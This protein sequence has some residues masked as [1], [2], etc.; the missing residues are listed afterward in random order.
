MFRFPVSKPGLGIEI[1]ASAIRLVA[2]SRKGA[3]VTALFAKKAELPPETIGETY[4]SPNILNVDRFSMVL[5]VCLNEAPR[6]IRRA[7][8]SLPDGVFRVQTF[9]F[10]ALPGKP[11]DRERLIRWRLEK[12]AAFD[13]TETLLRYQVLG[14]QDKGYLILACVAKQT[15]INQYEAVLA[16]Q[17][18]EL[19]SVGLSSFYILNFF[20]PRITGLS[21][22][23]ALAHVTEDSF[24]TIVAGAGGAR[25][26]RY[27]EIK[28]AG[29]DD[30]KIKFMREI[31]DSL[32][33]YTHMDR[34]QQPE[35]KRL[36][37]SG[38]QNVSLGL[39][40]GFKSMTSREVEVLSPADV[41]SSANSIGVE[42]AAAV[43]AGSSI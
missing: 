33:F 27:K 14:N 7:A 19:W 18:L 30:L 23:S 12:T 38:E 9:E 5:K 8:L 20:S 1:T 15:V 40:D 11:A 41:V 26:Y 21:E 34:T 4:S 29:T 32:H 35:V 37:L 22:V 36:F 3:N 42:M 25:F 2:V 10:D 13:S 31:E 39:A 6:G 43:S 24:A 16:A 28:R 17:G